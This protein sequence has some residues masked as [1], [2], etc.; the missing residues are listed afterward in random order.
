[1]TGF[2]GT[3]GKKLSLI[4]ERYTSQEFWR[5]YFMGSIVSFI[6]MKGGVGK[7]TLCINIGYT[8]AFHFNKKVLIIDMDPQFNAT[9]ALMEKFKSTQYYE[10]I[11]KE[12]KTISYVLNHS[13]GGVTSKVSELSVHDIIE[14]LENQQLHLIPG[15]LAII[16]FESSRRGSE[17]IL[18][19]YIEK[20]NLKSS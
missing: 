15:D 3:Y 2:L 16:D 4:Q 6:N 10:D 19:E 8:L 18:K 20:N 5:M 1:M 14:K 7:T 13:F 11:Q 9:Q 12:N 17:K